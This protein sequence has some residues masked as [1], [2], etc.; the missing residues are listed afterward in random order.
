MPLLSRLL[1]SSVGSQ[2]FQVDHT[3]LGGSPSLSELRT[4]EGL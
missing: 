4:S 1:V 3:A 2:A